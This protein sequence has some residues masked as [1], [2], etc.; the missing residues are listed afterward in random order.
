MVTRDWTPLEPDVV[1]QKTYAR[2]I[3]LVHEEKVDRSEVVELVEFTPGA[4]G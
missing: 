3:G 2:G 4:A 1:E